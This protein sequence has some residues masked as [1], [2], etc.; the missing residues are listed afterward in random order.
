[1]AR[2]SKR[3]F[4]LHRKAFSYELVDDIISAARRQPGTLISGGHRQIDLMKLKEGKRPLSDDL[5]KTML[6]SLEKLPRVKKGQAIHHAKLLKVKP[7]GREQVLH[8]DSYQE[9]D[10][11]ICHLNDCPMPATEVLLGR[12][13]PPV[14]GRPGSPDPS[15][16]PVPWP[17]EKKNLLQATANKGDVM[18]FRSSQR[19]RG[20]ANSAKVARLVLFMVLGPP[21]TDD[22]KRFDD[23][24]SVYEFEHAKNVYGSGS[25]QHIAALLRYDDP[26]TPTNM[27]PYDPAMHYWIKGNPAQYDKLR[28][29]MKPKKKIGFPE[30]A[31]SLDVLAQAAAM[32][33][34]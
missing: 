16:W 34:A 6:K 11:F 13:E 12:Y 28:K 26:Q 21:F 22:A 25:A 5:L 15:T 18:W 1:M 9:F 29:L 3:P 7:G 4:Q 24:S 32:H 27:K 20:P 14:M 2:W 8:A 33:R 19:H 23:E 31:S 10:A 30:S 17:L